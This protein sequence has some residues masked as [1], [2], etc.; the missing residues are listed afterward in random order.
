M[1][2]DLI[3]Q[4]RIIQKTMDERFPSTPEWEDEHPLLAT[5]IVISA[6]LLNSNIYVAIG[7]KIVKVAMG[8][9]V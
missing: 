8:V 1:K 7:V 5:I 4:R 9:G 3:S 2:N 6:L